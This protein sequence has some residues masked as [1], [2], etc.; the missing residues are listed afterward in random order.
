MIQDRKK[1]LMV[2]GLGLFVVLLLWAA[3]TAHQCGYSGGHWY[4]LYCV[5]GK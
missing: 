5:E 3:V 4:V 2:Y 1:A